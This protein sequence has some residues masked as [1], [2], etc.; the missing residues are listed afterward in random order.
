[1]AVWRLQT[2][3]AGGKIG[4]YC[5]KKGIAA[6]GWSLRELDPAIRKTIC[7]FSMYCYY[8]DS[9]Y[10]TYTS[11]RRILDIRAGDFIWIRHEGQYYLGHVSKHSHWIFNLDE[12]A[13]KL[14]ASNQLTDIQWIC[15]QESDESTVPGAISTAFIMGPALQRINK[16]GVE[17]FCKLLY[18][19]EMKQ[20]IY[21]VDFAITSETFYSMLS[22]SDCEDLLCMWLY[23]KYGY[24]CIPST[25]KLSTQLYECVLIDPASSKHIYIQV[26]NGTVDIDANKYVNLKGDIWFLTTHG[27]V[28]NI[29]K[30]YNMYICDPKELYAFAMSDLSQNILPPSIKSWGEFW[31]ENE[32]QNSNNDQ[33]G[34][35]FDTNKSYDIQSQEYMI[36]NNRI[37]AWGDAGRYVDRFSKGDYVLYYERGKEIIA[38]GKIL[39]ENTLQNNLER[40][41]NVLMVVPFCDNKFISPS[42]I[43]QLLNKN[44]YFASTIKTSYLSKN[45]VEMLIDVLESK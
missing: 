3:T 36:S 23:Y 2:K 16:P 21:P 28:L 9:A 5:L 39:S 35:I 22:P 17:N 14:D 38:I 24:I 6:V 27:H 44:F 19:R 30:H 1:M 31:E 7:N 15:Y 4:D 42:E 32:R 40:Y 25:N 29:D 41:R 8:A 12:E 13:T 34:I 11:V 26:K 18:N 37:S 33:K 45:E 43:K 10:R 20:N